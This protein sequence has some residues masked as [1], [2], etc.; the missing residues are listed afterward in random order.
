MSIAKLRSGRVHPEGSDPPVS[1]T[2]SGR[3]RSLR[4]ANSGKPDAAAEAR[5]AA[6]LLPEPEHAAWLAGQ[7]R[8]EG[9]QATRDLLRLYG[10]MLMPVAV[11]ATYMFALMAGLSYAIPNLLCNKVARENSVRSGTAGP[12]LL[13]CGAAGTLEPPSAA[14]RMPAR[15]PRRR[16][17]PALRGSTCAP[18]A[19]DHR[20]LPLAWPSAST[21]MWGPRERTRCGQ[22]VQLVAGWAAQAS[23]LPQQAPDPGNP[24]CRCAGAPSSSGS[25]SGL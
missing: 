7:A 1:R 12:G 17:R 10:K 21:M 11:C 5:A 3:Q 15:L 9:R 8:R 20:A 19:P 6:A 14:A 25:S 16:R 2:T 22:R 4:R 13:A 23:C 24:A 18:C